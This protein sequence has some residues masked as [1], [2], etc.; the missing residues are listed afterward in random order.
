MTKFAKAM[1]GVIILL[2]FLQGNAANAD[3]TSNYEEVLT[4]NPGVSQGVVK[5]VSSGA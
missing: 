1:A 5:V 4:L 2:M 3:D